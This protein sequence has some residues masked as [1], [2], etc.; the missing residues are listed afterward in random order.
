[1]EV[2]LLN[3]SLRTLF[4]GFMDNHALSPS[5]DRTVINSPPEIETYILSTP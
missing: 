5:Y 4:K 3:K 2:V 1:M